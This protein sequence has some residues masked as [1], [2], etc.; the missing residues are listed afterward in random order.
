M[1]VSRDKGMIMKIEK[2]K[3]YILTPEGEFRQC[4]SEP[5][6]MVGDEVQIP[7]LRSWTSR[8]PYSVAAA[9]AVLLVLITIFFPFNGGSSTHRIVAY[10]TLDINPSI[11]LGIDQ[12]N[13]VR[14]AEGL[15]LEGEQI[16]QQLT[17][18]GSKLDETAA[19]IIKSADEAGVIARHIDGNSGEIVVTTTVVTEEEWDSHTVREKVKQSIQAELAVLH[20][21]DASKVNVDDVATPPAVREEARREG[22]STGKMAVK[23]LAENKGLELSSEQ[24]QQQPIGQVLKEAG[25]MSSLLDQADTGNEAAQLLN[26]L[27]DKRRHSMVQQTNPPVHTIQPE[28]KS[29][30]TDKG[31]GKEHPRQGKA[32][33]HKK[34]EP[35]VQR[36]KPV[37]KEPTLPAQ[38]DESSNDR[39]REKGPQDKQQRMDEKKYKK[40][41]RKQSNERKAEEKKD[42]SEEKG[43]TEERGEG[44]RRDVPL[45]V[46]EK[47][48]EEG[49][50]KRSDKANDERDMREDT[51]TRGEEKEES[52]NK[53][54]DDR[55]Q[56]KS[57]DINKLQEQKDRQ[58]K[59]TEPE[60]RNKKGNQARE[61]RPKDEGKGPKDK[62]KRP[63]AESKQPKDEV[64][65]SH[66]SR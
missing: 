27:V 14:S 26:E 25:G 7:E 46:N 43:K 42:K 33:G 29:D 23:L 9:V 64:D 24:L 28:P 20:K 2:R 61:S 47:Q 36:E 44:K 32:A 53:H 16:I 58:K 30:E 59:D 17:P 57:E 66:F 1:S 31:K 19:A 37:K 52:R 12:D 62:D 60:E 13:I 65:R 4:A 39:D 3:A 49:K 8:V 40:E 45:P 50:G 34:D 63:K 11:E 54:R 22:I 10:V 38:I 15:N 48:S 51:G 5:H 55:G 41:E 35:N 6:W 56:K 21:E 18:V